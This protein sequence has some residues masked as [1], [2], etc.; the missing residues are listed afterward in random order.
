MC[1]MADNDFRISDQGLGL[2]SRGAFELKFCYYHPYTSRVY[3][4]PTPAR[5]CPRLE[6]LMLVFAS[7][8]RVS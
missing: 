6:S 4:D 5:A 8:A 3:T 1:R 2:I 7:L